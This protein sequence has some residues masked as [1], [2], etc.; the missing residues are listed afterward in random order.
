MIDPTHDV[1][2][3]GAKLGLP[4]TA[5]RP[6]GRDKAKIEVGA[7]GALKPAGALILVTAITPTSSRRGQDGQHDRPGPGADVH[8]GDNVAA[9][10]LREPSLGP[11]FGLKG[12]AT[13][14][15]KSIGCMPVADINLHFNGDFHAIT[16]AHNLLAGA[17]RQPPAP[18]P[19]RPRSIPRRSRGSARWT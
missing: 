7:L 4:A 9:A 6:Y 17:A 19:S 15:G 1:T 14:G 2:E 5:L 18:R 12:G 3:I 16:S 8:I 10:A 11:V 13:G